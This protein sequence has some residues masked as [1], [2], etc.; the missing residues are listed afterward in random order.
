MIKGL[1]VKINVGGSIG[2]Q[3]VKTEF[4]HDSIIDYY[5]LKGI[6]KELTESNGMNINL[7]GI[8]LLVNR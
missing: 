1:P 4:W 7:L 8:Q 3:N 2:N 6:I 5:L